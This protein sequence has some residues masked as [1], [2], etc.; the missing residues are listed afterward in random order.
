MDP[1]SAFSLACGVLQVVDFSCKLISTINDFYKKGSLGEND[2]LERQSSH[3]TALR[4]AMNSDR[5]IDSTSNQ[6]HQELLKLAGE[7]DATAQEL[8]E[9]LDALKVSGSNRLWKSFDKSFT[10][11]RRKGAI[12]RLNKRLDSFRKVLDT[13]ILINLR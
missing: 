1:L 3:L 10:A 5:A 13:R 7:C 9:Q 12:D 8:L 2:D 4:S 11:M 6:G